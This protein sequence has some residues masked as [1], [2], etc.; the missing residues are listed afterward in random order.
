MH[1]YKQMIKYNLY[2]NNLKTK[3]VQ[4]NKEP[5]SFVEFFIVHFCSSPILICVIF[6]LNL[7]NIFTVYVEYNIEPNTNW[8]I[9]VQITTPI[10]K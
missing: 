8:P 5:N 1:R 4:I 10:S 9:N 7:K 3:H 2:N 6:H